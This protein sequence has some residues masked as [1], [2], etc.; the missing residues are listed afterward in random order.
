[1]FGIDPSVLQLQLHLENMQTVAFKE[2]DNLEDV[3]NRPSSS[4]TMLTEYFKMNQVDP[5][6]KNFLYK[7]FREFYR[8]IKGKK[9]W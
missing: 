2:G 6:A 9:K 5:Y 3:V 8:W 4:S 7:E 1:M